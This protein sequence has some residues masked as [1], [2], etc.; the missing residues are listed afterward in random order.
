MALGNFYAALRSPKRGIIKLHPGYIGTQTAIIPIPF[1]FRSEPNISIGM[2]KTT[3]YTNCLWIFYVVVP[4][5][6]CRKK[7]Q[8]LQLKDAGLLLRIGFRTEKTL[9]NR[10]R[11]A[12]SPCH[13]PLSDRG[14]QAVSDTA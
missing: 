6:Y 13:L 7:S 11:T 10:I 1:Y 14:Y 4:G 12:T 3:L 5:G 2:E 9:S 8:L